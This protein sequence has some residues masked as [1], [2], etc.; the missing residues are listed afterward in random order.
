MCRFLLFVF[1]IQALVKALLAEDIV[2]AKKSIKKWA[3]KLADRILKLVPIHHNHLESTMLAKPDHCALPF[4][5]DPQYPSIFIGTYVRLPIQVNTMSRPDFSGATTSKA[6]RLAAM[7]AE[8]LA[9]GTS[10]RLR[11]AG[12][13]LASRETSLSHTSLRT[14]T[15]APFDWTSPVPVHGASPRRL[16]DTMQR[17][18]ISNFDSPQGQRDNHS[19]VTQTNLSHREIVLAALSHHA[20]TIFE[21]LRSKGYSVID[22]FLPTEA[23]LVMR[24]EAAALHR[25]GLMTPTSIQGRREDGKPVKIHR[26]GYFSFEDLFQE[27]LSPCLFWFHEVL[28]DNVP[29]VFKS[30]FPEAPLGNYVW[31]HRLTVTTGKGSDNPLHRDRFPATDLRKLTTILYLQSNW[32]AQ[33]GGCLRMFE[34]TDPPD[35]DLEKV[36]LGKYV[37]IP[38]LG[39][40]L[41][42]FWSDKMPHCVL[43]TYA[44]S[45]ESHR[46]AFTIWFPSDNAQFRIERMMED[47]CVLSEEVE[48]V[49]PDLSREHLDQR[50]DQAFEKKFGYTLK[51]KHESIKREFGLDETVDL[52]KDF[53]EV[54]FASEFEDHH[55]E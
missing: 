29:N 14:P 15:L 51:E 26:Q 12:Q 9:H 18:N 38:P 23:I 16:G 53:F 54:R 7:I 30:Q 46:W 4:L 10:A 49:Y 47:W 48:S 40:R 42:I 5:P 39:G 32:S 3:V 55:I 1:V 2:Y 35:A 41:L 44:L 50:V 20:P 37:D 21:G 28:R 34:P 43:P 31:G 13:A 45:A 19:S 36:D 25:S 6:T 11:A 27:D 17:T 24:E 52:M 22:N 33:Q 8:L